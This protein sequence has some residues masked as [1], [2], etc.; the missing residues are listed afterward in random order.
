MNHKQSSTNGLSLL[1]KGV[2]GFSQAQDA[3][4]FYNN[5]NVDIESLNNPILEKGLKEI[6]K[7]CSEYL[8][9]AHDWSLANY[10]N[11]TAKNDCIETKRSNTTNAISKGYDLQSS[12]AISDI[13]GKPI[14]PLVH[15]LKTKDKIFSTYDHAIDMELTHLNELSI[16]ISYINNEMDINK[17]IVHIID[18]EADSIGF[19]RELDKNDLYI[20]R[21]LDR[22]TVEYK[23]SKITQKE[24]A[25]TIELG[26]YIKTIDYKKKRVKIYVNS[27]DIEITRDAYIKETNDKGKVRHKRVKGKAVKSRFIVERLVDK[28]NNVVATWL[29]L[30]NLKDDVDAKTIGLWYYYRWKIEIYFKLLKSSGF[31]LEKWQ[32]ETSGAIFKRLL[33]ASYACLLVWQIEHS[34]HKNII[35][36][37][38]FLVKLS[39]RLVARGKDSTS[40]ALLAG[41]WSFFSAMDILELYDIEKLMAMKN[42][43]NEFMGMDF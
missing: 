17:R 2:K 16:R 4:R 22:A 18:R 6:E 26:E 8:L 25:K 39:G 40:P 19:F 41:I 1:I 27:V 7:V 28:E 14:T 34:N 21:A 29:L 31:N 20:V 43:L 10:R 24:L 42:E 3:W 38:K 35:E 23:G 37:K 30:S 15:N 5:D 13:T 32:Q 12:L 11:H 36:I 9:V 33:I